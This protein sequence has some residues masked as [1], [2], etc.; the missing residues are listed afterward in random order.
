MAEDPVAWLANHVAA[1]IHLREECRNLP[2]TALEDWHGRAKQW[3]N[4]LRDGIA[5][6]SP[7]DVGK[8]ETLGWLD[9]G[10]P[11][12][13]PAHRWHDPQIAEMAR[14]S[15]A[16]GMRAGSCLDVTTAAGDDCFAKPR[17]ARIEMDTTNPAEIAAAAYPIT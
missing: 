9:V 5:A 12:L 11:Q 13:M 3:A 1:G 6:R 7:R 15:T 10:A 4:E 17:D 14:S 2:D 16:A 8:V